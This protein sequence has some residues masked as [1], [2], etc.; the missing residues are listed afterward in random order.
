MKSDASCKCEKFTLRRCMQRDRTWIIPPM[1]TSRILWKLSSI[2]E[3]GGC[4]RVAVLSGEQIRFLWF[5]E[6]ARE[7]LR[8]NA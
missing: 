6:E 4:V 7:V 8:P 3:G 5:W 2:G 1:G